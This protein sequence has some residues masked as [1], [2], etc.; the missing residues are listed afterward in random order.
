[1]CGQVRGPVQIGF[2]RSIDPI[3]PQEITITRVAI[4]TEADAEKKSTEMGR[5]H[6]VPYG[7]YRAEGYVSAN[8]ARRV[9]GFSQ[10]D[11]ELLWESIINMFEHDHS[12]ARGK[13]AVREL[14]VFEHE[15]ELGNAPAHKLFDLVQ[16]ERKKANGVPR[17]YSDY[18]VTIQ[19]A[20]IP[21]GVELKRLV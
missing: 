6:I 15:S 7:L 14:I 17:S 1:N 19:E 5:K 8:L 21:E 2:A 4:T 18:A 10:S 16:V 11:L 20:E 9:T 3:V 13:M 12:A